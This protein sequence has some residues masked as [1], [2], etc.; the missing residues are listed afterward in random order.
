MVKFEQH[1]NRTDGGC[2]V[3]GGPKDGCG[4]GLL[5][6]G[7]KRLSAHRF[8]LMLKTGDAGEGMVAMHSCDTPAC[9]NPDHLSWGT[10]G[11]NMR[12]MVAKGRNAGKT[13]VGARH[14]AAKY[15]EEDIRAIRASDESHTD[16][17]KKYGVTPQSIAYVRV[18]GWTSVSGATVAFKRGN[19]GRKGSE[20]KTA[21][22]T[23]DAVREIRASVERTAILAAKY[24]VTSDCI[25][26]VK[27]RIRWSHV[28]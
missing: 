2:W 19:K 13:A 8:S 18:K 23:E 10:Q 4:Y 17:A 21:I 1:C 20:N 16:L 22:L 28:E 7:A 15:S 11:D 5:H 6:C 24:G 3:W 14:P 9:V 12:D 26:Q 27:R 25:R